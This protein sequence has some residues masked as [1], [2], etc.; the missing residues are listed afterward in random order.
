[1][2][3]DSLDHLVMTV[4]DIDITC[5]FYSR[6]MGINVIHF[7][8]KRTALTFGRQKINLHESDSEFAP[9]AS[10]PKPGSL[11]LCLLTKRS[12]KT[13]ISHLRQLDIPIIEGPVQRTGATGPIQSVYFRD[14][15]GNL[16][17]IAHPL[18]GDSTENPHS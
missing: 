9:K 2:H 5:D 6:V 16:L 15:D 12:I 11:D 13:I 7:G 1:M 3:I 4:N 8:D 18:D 10:C 14:P 17:E